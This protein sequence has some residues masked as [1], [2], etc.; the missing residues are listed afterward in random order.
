MGKHGPRLN[1][2]Y[3][4][5]VYRRYP[6]SASRHL[7]VYWYAQR[8]MALHR[9]IW[10]H[11]RG[12]IPRGMHVHHKNGDPLDNRIGNLELVT[13]SEHGRHHMEDPGR[14]A[15]SSAALD[16]AREAAPAWHRS[17]E[18]RAWHRAHGK[19]VM[20]ARPMHD[21]LCIVCDR[22]FSS[23]DAGA[24][25][26]SA[27]CHAKRRRDS[28]LDDVEF[29]CAECGRKFMRNKYGKAVNCSRAC[30]GCANGRRRRGL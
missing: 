6:Q 20:A 11:H 18:G 4:G 28:G 14:K 24:K 7:R 19:R 21:C 27:K 3:R 26:C 15:M 13:R 22:G 25:V 30:T 1:L 29:T 10:K 16:K 9:E 12:P 23:K 5:V 17:R 2:T 8:G